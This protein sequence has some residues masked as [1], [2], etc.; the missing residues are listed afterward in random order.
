MWTPGL[1]RRGGPRW[2]P[3][4]ASPLTPFPQ[5]LGAASTPIA[6]HLLFWSLRTP[7]FSGERRSLSQTQL[8]TTREK[9]GAARQGRYRDGARLSAPWG[10]QGPGAPLHPRGGLRTD[11]RLRCKSQAG[12]TRLT[13]MKQSRQPPECNF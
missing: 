2:L 1:Q 13:A 6:T 8:W 10:A 5:P 7:R 3:G 9:A 12:G 11:V 4:P